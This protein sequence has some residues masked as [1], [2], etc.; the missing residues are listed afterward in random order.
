MICVA[1]VTNKGRENCFRIFPQ[2]LK[3]MTEDFEN[4]FQILLTNIW[5]QWCVNKMRNPH[6]DLKKSRLIKKN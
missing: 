4:K 5:G 3:P 1:L 2:F 6:L